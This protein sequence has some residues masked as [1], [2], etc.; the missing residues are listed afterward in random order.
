MIDAVRSVS[1]ND[2]MP[3]GN[4]INKPTEARAVQL[5]DKTRELEQARLDAVEARQRV[6]DV[7]DQIEGVPGDVL[8]LRY[9]QLKR[10]EEICVD[11][12][13]S[14][15]Q[16]HRNHVEGLVRVSAILENMA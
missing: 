3:H 11:V 6:F 15:R 5:A 10:W 1:D 4:G 13:Q 12:H 14:W 2:G 7:V 9:V 16:T 8:Y